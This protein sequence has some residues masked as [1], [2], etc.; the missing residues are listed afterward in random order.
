MALI[1]CPECSNEVSDKA[2]SCPKCGHPLQATAPQPT[3]DS[4]TLIKQTLSRYGKI[5]AIKV[6]R[7]HNPSAGLADAK[8]Y[9]ENL[10]AGLP[11]GTLGKPPQQADVGG[12]LVILAVIA[13]VAVFGGLYVWYSSPS[14]APSAPV[15]QPAA[16]S[17]SVS[18]PSPDVPLSSISWSEIDAIYNLKNKY[19]DL[20]KDESW[21][22]YK[23][24][25]IRWS[26]TVSSVADSFGSLS[27]QVKMNPDTFTSDVLVTLKESQKSKALTLKEGDFVTFTGIL[28]RWGSILPITLNEG[29]ID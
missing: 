12:C 2:A 13:L 20:Q 23:G 6:Y 1:K 15:A 16:A 9:V 11:P 24:K 17:P 19:T 25:K 28:D 4:D 29:E 10:A 3:A 22:Q 14:S 7:T 21:K 5:A 27:L 18:A 26:G 8:Q